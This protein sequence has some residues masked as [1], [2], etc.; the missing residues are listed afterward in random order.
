MS[1]SFLFVVEGER[2]EPRFF[3]R[4]LPMYLDIG[5]PSIHSYGTNIHAL[6][7][8]F[9]V[10]GVIDP[11]LDLM[12]VLRGS[13]TGRRDDGILDRRFTDIIMVFDMDPLDPRYDPE[14]LRQAAEFFNDSSGNG[15]LY[16]NY[17]MF[18]SYRHMPSLHDESYL[19]ISVNRDGIK[20]YKEVSAL[21]ANSCGE[22]R[23]LSK[24]GRP[25]FDRIIE[26]NLRKACLISSGSRVMPSAEDYDDRMD[27]VGI[28][29]RQCRRFEGSG[30]VMVLNTSVLCV[31][32]Y[33]PAVLLGSLCGT[34]SRP[35][36]VPD[37]G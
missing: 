6:L 15:K 10:D 17:P 11:D 24:I 9:F 8:E 12:K 28:L 32:D 29:E 2:T 22:L 4:M 7:D 3:R 31:V 20:R 25:A 33:N 18:E 21:P 14:R 35:D 36:E 26:M 27:H 13:R 1:K 37:R 16:I 34:P 23:E 30:T 19:G 5:P